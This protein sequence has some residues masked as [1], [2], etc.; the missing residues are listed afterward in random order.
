MKGLRSTRKKNSLE[1][2]KQ[3]YSYGQFFVDRIMLLKNDY[4]E[5]IENATFA[6]HCEYCLGVAR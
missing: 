2:S 4:I 3:Y 1:V 6:S 5:A